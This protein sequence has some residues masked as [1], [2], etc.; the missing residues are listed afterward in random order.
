[1][2]RVILKMRKLSDQ[3][4]KGRPA[5]VPV[6]PERQEKKRAEYFK[7]EDFQWLSEMQHVL[8]PYWSARFGR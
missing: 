2:K 6:M 4:M 3:V 7:K 5:G 1:M 8:S